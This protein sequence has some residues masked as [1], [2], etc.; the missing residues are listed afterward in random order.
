[1]M[2]IDQV[3]MMGGFQESKRILCQGARAGGKGRNQEPGPFLTT[4]ES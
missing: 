4:A 3:V 2:A 1:M